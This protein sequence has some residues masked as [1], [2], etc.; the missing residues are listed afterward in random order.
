M[1]ALDVGEGG[2]VT[3]QRLRLP[4]KPA[5]DA[6]GSF[7]VEQA[8]E[9]FSRLHNCASAL[10]RGGHLHALVVGIELHRLRL[11]ASALVE[12]WVLVPLEH[13]EYDMSR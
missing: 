9:E 8:L 11:Y 4:S 7:R 13:I 2:V 5:R 6:R 12:G 10:V 1:D 3:Q